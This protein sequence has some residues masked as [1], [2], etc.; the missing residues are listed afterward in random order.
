MADRNKDITKEKICSYCGEDLEAE[1]D[2]CGDTL[3]TGDEI[4]CVA[5][6]GHFCE[7]CVD[8]AWLEDIEEDRA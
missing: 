8:P 7:D 1:C 6:T 4:H 5:N 2:S 3:E